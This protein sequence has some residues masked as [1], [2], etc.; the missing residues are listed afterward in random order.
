MRS[1]RRRFVTGGAVGLLVLLGRRRRRAL[2]PG[3][4]AFEAAPCF[5]E[6]HGSPSSRG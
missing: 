6:E 3:L 1:W 2:A 4:E 5:R